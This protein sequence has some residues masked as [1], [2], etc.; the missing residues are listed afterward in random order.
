MHFFTCFL[1]DMDRDGSNR[2]PR[3]VTQDAAP[4]LNS[5]GKPLLLIGIRLDVNAHCKCFRVDCHVG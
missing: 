3:P 4:T 5:A 1:A 2:A